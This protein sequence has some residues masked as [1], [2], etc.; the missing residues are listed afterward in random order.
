[1]ILWL[2]VKLG[3]VVELINQ[4]LFVCLIGPLAREKER[5]YPL[6]RVFASPVFALPPQIL[7]HCNAT[8]R[9][10]E[11]NRYFENVFNLYHFFLLWSRVVQDQ[12]DR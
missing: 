7:R 10:S 1:M 3:L 2:T 11:S 12:M 4:T 8:V 5:G 6:F 9:R